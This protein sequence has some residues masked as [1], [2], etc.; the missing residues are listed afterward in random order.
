MALKRRCQYRSSNDGMI[1]YQC[2][3]KYTGVR[4]RGFMLIIP[5]FLEL[6][7]KARKY[8]SH[9]SLLWGRVLKLLPPEYE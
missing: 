3:G 7:N 1:N 8:V 5:R 4:Y 6:L 2:F 9:S